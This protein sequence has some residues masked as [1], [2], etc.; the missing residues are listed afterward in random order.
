MAD[1][2]SRVPVQSV[3][4][5]RNGKFE[6]PELGKPFNFTQ[7][8]IDDIEASNPGAIRKPVV[9]KADEPAAKPAAKTAG[10]AKADEGL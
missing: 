5:V 3:V 4:V 9:E 2:I 7:L 6:T 10:K 8:E 1:L